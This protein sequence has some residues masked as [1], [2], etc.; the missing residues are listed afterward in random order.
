[1]TSPPKICLFGAAPSTG[2]LGVSALFHSAV[3]GI[4]DAHA[5]SQ[6]TVFDFGWTRKE[7]PVRLGDREF[8]VR[9]A[10]ANPSKRFWRHDT[11]GN[12]RWM[13]RLGGLGNPGVRDIRQ[14]QAVWDVSG[15]DSFTDLYGV[16]RFWTTV[17]PKFLALDAGRPLVLLP[18]TYGPFSDPEL[19]KVAKAVTARAATAWARDQ[20]SFESLQ[21]LLGSSFDPDKHRVGVD[22]AFGLPPTPA[23]AGVVDDGARAWLE[24]SNGTVGV[25]VSGLIYLDPKA[26]RERYGF[27]ADYPKLIHGLV[28]GLIERNQNVI[29]VPHVIEPRGNVESDPE[30]CRQVFGALTPAEQER[31]SILTPPYTAAEVKHVLSKLDWFCGTRMHSTI[32]ALSSGVPTAAVAYSLKFQG[33]FETCDQASGVSDPREL[34]TGDA[35]ERLL[36]HFENRDRERGVLA[37]ALPRVKDRAAQQMAHLR[38]VSGIRPGA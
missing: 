9:L 29:L 3:A 26:A 21:E 12:M 25:N 4:F 2:N 8:R 36:G 37:A 31:V 19:R 11:L 18:Q 6:I 15:G 17:A 14:S 24:E 27:R 20:R 32:G 28:R 7:L 34:E 33:V 38:E 16:K 5:E 30:A 35:L 23:R 10:G 1:M 22:L 13:N